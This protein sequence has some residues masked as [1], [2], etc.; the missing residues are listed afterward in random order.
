MSNDY[1]LDDNE[2][3]E[4]GA[5]G[6]DQALLDPFEGLTKRDQDIFFRV[7]DLLPREQLETA[8]DY[9]M[10]RPQKIHAVV[11]YV[12]HQ[13]ELIQKGDIEGLKKLFEQEQIVLDTIDSAAAMNE[14]SEV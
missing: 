1:E 5:D 11:G 2:L 8:M 4:W 7:L 6:G 13:K 12:K 10:S 3:D 14:E 9:F